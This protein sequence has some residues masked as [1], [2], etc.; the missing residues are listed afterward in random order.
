MPREH[1]LRLLERL[2]GVARAHRQSHVLLKRPA[3]DAAVVVDGDGA[4]ERQSLHLP[5]VGGLE[6]VQQAEDVD[7][8][9]GLGGRRVITRPGKVAYAIEAVLLAQLLETGSIGD[10]QLLD[11]GVRTKVVAQKLGLASG[12]VL[13]Q[14]DILAGVDE[15]ARSMQADEAKAAGDQDH[16]GF[17]FSQAT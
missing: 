6:H 10:V 2:D 4:G 15:G 3:V 12:A 1:F 13:R 5:A 8:V 11:K 16:S 14:H 9:V 7:L 17:S